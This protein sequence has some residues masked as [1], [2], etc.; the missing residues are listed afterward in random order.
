MLFEALSE[1]FLLKFVPTVKFN[2]FL[3]RDIKYNKIAIRN[4]SLS[5]L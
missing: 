2:I 4:A 1:I 5:F 3:Y